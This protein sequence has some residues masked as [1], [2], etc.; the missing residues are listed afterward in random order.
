MPAQKSLTLPDPLTLTI[1]IDHHNSFCIQN[2]FEQYCAVFFLYCCIIL[3]AGNIE[4]L[5]SIFAYVD[6]FMYVQL[7]ICMCLG[8]EALLYAF[9]W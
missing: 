9:M 4:E 8:K 3:K 6:L 5:I 1:S 7:Y 2:F